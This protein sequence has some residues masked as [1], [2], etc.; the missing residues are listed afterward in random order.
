M[1]FKLFIQKFLFPVDCSKDLTIEILKEE[2][3]RKNKI[4]G[5]ATIPFL[6]LIN[7]TRN[8]FVNLFY[9]L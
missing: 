2:H 3:L 9:F 1:F 5:V 8:R 7:S 4:L 6:D